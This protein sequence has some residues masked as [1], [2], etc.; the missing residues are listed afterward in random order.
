MSVSIY[1]YLVV[2]VEIDN[3]QLYNEI[4]VP[5]CRHNPSPEVQFCPQCGRAAWIKESVPIPG[6]EDEDKYH[7]LDVVCI[8][9]AGDGRRVVGRELA[10][11]SD[12]NDE[13]AASVEASTISDTVTRVK[14][15]LAG[16]PLETAGEVKPMV[17]MY[18]SY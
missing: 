5:G 10:E 4:D 16:T 11:I 14:A 13:Y 12:Y 6:Y 17:C 18:I 9:C 8:G 15:K 3:A 7:Q 2:G 1:A